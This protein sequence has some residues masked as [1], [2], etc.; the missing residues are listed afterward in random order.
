MPHVHYKILSQL[1]YASWIQ[2]YTLEAFYT[3]CDFVFSQAFFIL[4]KQR[5]AG[6]MLVLDRGDINIGPW[7]LWC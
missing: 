4:D 5:F 1:M 6:E 7:K 3:A 2:D